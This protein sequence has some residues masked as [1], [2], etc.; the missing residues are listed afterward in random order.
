MHAHKIIHGNLRPQNIMIDSFGHIVL[1]GFGRAQSI[2]SNNQRDPTRPCGSGEYQ[3]PE[4][5]LGW[6]HDLA[7][8][9]WSFGILL[10]M[11]LVGI[12]RQLSSQEH[13]YSEFQAADSDPASFRGPKRASGLGQHEEQD[14][15]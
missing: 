10:Y 7:V 15:Q 13:L 12:V 2:C 8:D 14:Y 3:P 5:I 4:M 9:C 11:M 6:N 1:T